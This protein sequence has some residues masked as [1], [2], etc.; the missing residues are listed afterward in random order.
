MISIDTTEI[1]VLYKETNQ[2]ISATFSALLIKIN[3]A[4]HGVNIG[5]TLSKPI[6]LVGVN[7]FIRESRPRFELCIVDVL[8]NK[9]HCTLHLM[10][11]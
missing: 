1:E 2:I 5:Y 11:I 9:L 7:H 4:R 3:I 8:V 6:R 10:F